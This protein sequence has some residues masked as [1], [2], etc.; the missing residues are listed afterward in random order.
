MNNSEY[1]FYPALDSH[2]YDSM[3]VGKKSIDDLKHICDS[4]NEY[5]GFN[6]LGFIKF[7]INCEL[8]PSKYFGTDDGLYVKKRTDA[9]TFNDYDFFP[10][11]DSRGNDVQYVNPNNIYHLK[12]Q[13]DRTGCAG[14]N[15]LGFLKSKMADVLHATNAE[16]GLYVRKRHNKFR[17]KLLC[18]WCTSD[19]L[20]K[21]WNRMSQGDYKWN[22]IEITAGNNADFFVIV[23]KPLSD[24]EYYVPD[25]TII[26]RMEPWCYDDKC[27]WGVKTWGKWARPDDAKF[28]QVRYHERYLNTTFWQLATTYS[29][30][31]SM[32]HI[33]KNQVISS[34][35]SSKY[36]DPGHILRIDFLKFVEAK[37]DEDV[38]IHVYNHDNHHNFK[39]YMGPH[40]HNNKDAAIMPYKY[41]FMMENNA[42]HN[43]VTEKIWESLICE[44]LCFYWGCPNLSDW[45][46]PRSYILLDVDDFEKSYQIMRNA[47]IT[48]E[49]SKRLPYIKREKQRVLDYYNFFPTLERTLK[50][51]FKFTY[52][53]SDL[54][55]KYNKYFHQ[56]INKKIN[57]GCFIHTYAAEINLLLETI[58]K[59]IVNSLIDDFDYV[60][61]I[62]I[63]CKNYSLMCDVIWQDKIVMINYS[64]D[65]ALTE[66]ASF[67][68]IHL[69][70][71]KNEDCKVM[72]LNTNKYCDNIID[73]YDT[74]SKLLCAHNFVGY[75]NAWLARCDNIKMIGLKDRNI[76]T[77]DSIG[78]YLTYDE[79]V[80]IKCVNLVRRPDRKKMV[81]EQLMREDLLEHTDFFEAV[82][83][84]NLE[85]TDEIKELFAGN[86]FKSRKGVIGCA[87]SHCKLWR[88][89]VSDDT[90]DRYLILE[91]DIEIA[92]NFV[93]KMNLVIEK[94]K[95]VEWDII[96]FGYH[97]TK[98]MNEDRVITIKEYDTNQNIGGTFGYLVTKAGAKKFLNFISDNGIRHGIDYLMFHY[99][100]EMNLKQF[101]VM[102]QLIVSEYVASSKAVD[103]DIQYDASSLF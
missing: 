63:G 79:K 19:E 62:N 75:E 87:L 8:H 39:N 57:N 36:Y 70:C 55:V 97:D 68:L 54:D 32:E 61:I 46:D 45:I 85:A 35:C 91:D 83:G 24:N 2:G 73:M 16:H 6:T 59:I 33:S 51:E 58:E 27:N 26:I 102:P 86:D 15:T 60:Y 89:L 101:Q 12:N 50:N 29:Q 18:N 64:E 56:T 48:D 17:V 84:Q 9:V 78:S 28:L 90:Y 65:V 40:P 21:D 3:F 43:F 80:R 53:P 49:W 67:D 99:H 30:F 4:S 23:N 94:M 11:L 98:Q 103:S 82:D 52:N 13:A 88:Q 47:I 74:C 1:I 71:Q 100:R 44:C 66:I 34:I 37:N 41:Y 72:F 95:D 42:E 96:Y 22:D 14:F 77:V 31:K 92:Q 10:G 25:R 5:M 93:L 69:F 7:S 76:F 20:C 81:M 38:K